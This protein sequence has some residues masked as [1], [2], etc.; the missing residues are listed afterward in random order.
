MDLPLNTIIE[1]RSLLINTSCVIEENN[2]Y[3]P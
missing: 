1:F 3:Y 2:E